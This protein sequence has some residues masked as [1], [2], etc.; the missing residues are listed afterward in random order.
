MQCPRDSLC[1][2]Q[3]V[4]LSPSCFEDTD[5]E[6]P[7]TSRCRVTALETDE[8]IP[9]RVELVKVVESIFFFLPRTSWKWHGEIDCS[10]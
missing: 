10:R 9:S 4:E 3:D 1:E 8:V 6:Q 5:P 2:P 7:A